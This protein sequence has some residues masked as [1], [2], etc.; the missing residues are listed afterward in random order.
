MNENERR[1]E[2]SRERMSSPVRLILFHYAYMTI[3]IQQSTHLMFQCFYE[4]HTSQTIF[5]HRLVFSRTGE[6]VRSWERSPEHRTTD[7]LEALHV[8]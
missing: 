7:R 3:K 8:V 4:P 5:I 2:R 6:L 1:G